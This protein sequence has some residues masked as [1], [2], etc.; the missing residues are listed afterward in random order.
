[1][2]AAQLVVGEVDGDSALVS[3]TEQDVPAVFRMPLNLLPPG[4]CVGTSHMTNTLPM[5]PCYRST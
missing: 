2:R 1:M 5:Q 4:V 3:T